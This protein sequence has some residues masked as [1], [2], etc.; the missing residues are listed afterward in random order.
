MVV[1][2]VPVEMKHTGVIYQI[3]ILVL[4][5][6]A[7]F[8]VSRYKKWA[9]YGLLLI[10][11]LIILNTLSTNKYYLAALPQTPTKNDIINYLQDLWMEEKC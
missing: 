10:S 9:A 5:V 7:F 6:L 1:G 2:K 3:V 11:L 8:G 4:N